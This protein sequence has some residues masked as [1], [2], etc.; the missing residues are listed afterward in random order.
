[1]SSPTASKSPGRN[2]LTLVWVC[3]VWVAVFANWP[4]W[5]A[6][7]RLPEMASLRG[8]CFIAAF[9]LMV[10]A[11][12][13]MLLSLFA[14]SRTAK[15]VAA[16]FLVC[17]AMA[18]YFMAT[19]HVVIDASMLQ[20]A[21]QTNW[22]ETRDLLSPQMAGYLL[23]LAGLPC[24]WLWRTAMAPAPSSRT[25]AV[26]NL[27]SMA[28][29]LVLMLSLLL[30]FFSDMSST[31]RNHKSI[32]YLIT[33]LNAYYA[34][35]SLAWG[36][37]AAPSGPLQIVAPDAHISAAAPSARP[38]LLL[39]VVGE[40]ARAA[41]FSV[42][43][44]GQPTNPG[45]TERKVI[46]F[47]QVSSCGTNTAA[48]LPCMFSPLGK[49]QFQADKRPHE[50]LLDVVQRAG[51]A[52]LWIDNQSGCKG[53]CDRVP[54][55]ATTALLPGMPPLPSSLCNSDG[56][57]LDEALLHG[58]DTRIQALPEAQRQRGIL[59]VMHQMGSHGPAYSKRSPL[60][61]KPFQPECTTNVLQ[62]CEPQALINA[63]DNSI[64]YTDH[65]LSRSI[66][67]LQTQ[68]SSHRVAM[69][70]LSDH[71]ESLGENNLYL[72]GMPY[73]LAPK[74]QTHIPM[75]LWLSA[76]FE[77]TAQLSRSC[78][79]AQRHQALTH[80]HLFHTTLGLLGIATQAYRPALDA[81]KACKN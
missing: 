80:D 13:A 6:L 47:D 9:A 11:G 28:G 17:A 72:H 45:L 33:P 27:V 21:L 39:L 40:T 62:Q 30:V 81:L 10:S 79:E 19:Y 59:L 20:N 74:E 37:K 15:P 26:V 52:V 57:C 55:S 70:Y 2:P 51:M 5:Q 36:A 31:M 29:A 49:T 73:A 56:E 58:L 66:D 42:Y 67:W 25:Q 16:F 38:P 7:S 77:Q 44:Y 23:V 22:H 46:A 24:L 63:Y 50:T 69:L 8:T 18:C 68:I 54:H 12:N 35:G 48:S 1:V 60:E 4:L 78:L 75:L 64:A 34:L 43:G 41:N 53:V 14:W 32:R 61:R 65:V 76:A 71:G 3:A